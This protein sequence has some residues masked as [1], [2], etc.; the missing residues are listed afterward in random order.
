[1]V[2]FKAHAR[3]VCWIAGFAYALGALTTLLTLW[4]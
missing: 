2:P 1:M 4:R 3:C